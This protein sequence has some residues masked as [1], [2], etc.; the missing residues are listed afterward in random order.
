MIYFTSDSHYNH[1]NIAGKEVSSWD[2]GYRN[3]ISVE[4][5]NQHI[6]DS[7][8]SVVKVGDT[9]IHAGDWSFGGINSIFEFRDR[10][11]CQDIILT[12]GNHDYHIKKNKSYNGR[13]PLD[14]FF[15][16]SK[17]YRLSHKEIPLIIVSHYSQRI[18]E[19]SH[20]GSI[21]LYGHSH[22]TLPQYVNA[23]GEPLRT[24]DIGYDVRP[25]PYSLDEILEMM[26]DRP[27]TNVDHHK[28]N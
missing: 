28:N 5:M 15:H 27:F 12:F 24:M 7:I 14:N 3:F 18:W 26:K 8:N 1:K 9:L 19:D 16:A 11:N 6:V 13:N 17:R 25:V 23:S 2:K 22:G 10:L 20:K 21:M 4:E